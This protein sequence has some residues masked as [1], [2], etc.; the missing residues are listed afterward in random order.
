MFTYSATVHRKVLSLIWAQVA[1]CKLTTGADLTVVNS[2][3]LQFRYTANTKVRR[4][5]LHGRKWRNFRHSCM[6]G[7]L[8]IQHQ[9]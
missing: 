6:H 7:Y 4:L 1:L 3:H 5:L 9:F 8:H 2:M